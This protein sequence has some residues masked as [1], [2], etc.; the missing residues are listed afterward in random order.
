MQV[1]V[2]AGCGVGGRRTQA[3]CLGRPRLIGACDKTSDL[4]RG[5]CSGRRRYLAEEGTR[6]SEE[7]TRNGSETRQEGKRLRET[8]MEEARFAMRLAWTARMR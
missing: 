4:R 1:Y 6:C 7:S 3:V 2:G 8:E 5:R